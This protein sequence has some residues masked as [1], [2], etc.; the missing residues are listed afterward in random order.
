MSFKP[1]RKTLSLC[2]ARQKS[3]AVFSRNLMMILSANVILGS[4]MPMLI[5]VGALAGAALSPVAY[6]ATPPPSVQMLAAVLA[7]APMSF[8]MGRVGRQKGFFTG[9]CLAD[10]GRGAGC[11]RNDPTTFYLAM[12]GTFCSWGSFFWD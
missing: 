5:L 7:A 9:G 6:A 11:G 3:P 12:C 1:S 4:A 10:F 8:Y 2:Q